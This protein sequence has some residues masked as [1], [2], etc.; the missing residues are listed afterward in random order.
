MRSQGT[1][2]PLK[3]Y[4]LLLEYDGS[5]FH[6][7]QLQPGRR[8]VQ[9][10]LEKA[11]KKLF[12]KAIHV[13]GASRTDAGVHAAGQVASFRTPRR[14]RGNLPSA[15]NAHLPPDI[16]VLSAGLAPAGFHAQKDARAKTYRYSFLNRSARPAR[17]RAA[18]GWVAAP[19]SM[20]RMRREARQ[21]VHRR[22]FADMAGRGSR[23][24]STVCRL[25]RLRVKRRGPLVTVEVTGD[26][27]LHRMV[28]RLVG[29]LVQAGRG[30]R[31]SQARTLESRGLELVKVHYGDVAT[32]FDNA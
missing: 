11:L 29:R 9:G 6:G 24:R 27:F 21:L 1:R 19:L 16:S 5:C 30:G 32:V 2:D 18:R 31:L 8:T 3:I 10:E 7:W 26:R 15:L 23:G 17:Q 13:V 14:F 12:H 20:D 25:L 22:R 4:R 28:R